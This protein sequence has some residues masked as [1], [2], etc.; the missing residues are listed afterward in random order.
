MSVFATPLPPTPIDTAAIGVI[1]PYDFALDREI[2]RWVPPSVTLHLTRTPYAAV[3]VGVTQAL[4]VGDPFEIAELARDLCAVGPQV[5]LYLCTAGSFARGLDGEREL[6]EAMASS[7]IPLAV[8][9]SGALL[10]AAGAL[11]I[12][13]IAIATPYDEVVTD[14]LTYYLEAAGL[15]VTGRRHL[16]LTGEIWRLTHRQVADLVRAAVAGSERADAVFLSCT[17]VRSYDLVGPLEAELGLPVLTANQVSMWAALRAV[18]L[19][20]NGDG[21]LCA[22]S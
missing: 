14:R 9:T 1:V 22:S 5:A 11:G 4:L 8:T 12:E 13:R 7:G 2:W 18:G 19:S 6:R 20:A 21:R 15:I 10:E 17:N 3:P 16:G